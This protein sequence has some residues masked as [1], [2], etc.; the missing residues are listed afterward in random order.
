M[1]IIIKSDSDFKVEL[2]DVLDII[3]LFDKEITKYKK[4]LVD[5]INNSCLTEEEIDIMMKK[6]NIEED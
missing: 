5:V 1:K 2:Q 6:Y 3:D 4:V